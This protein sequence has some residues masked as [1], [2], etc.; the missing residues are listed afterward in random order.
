MEDENE[1]VKVNYVPDD[2]LDS[3]PLEKKIDKK[4]VDQKRKPAQKKAQAKMKLI[5][6]VNFTITIFINTM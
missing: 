2:D 3:N 5:D 6:G 4:K 1:T